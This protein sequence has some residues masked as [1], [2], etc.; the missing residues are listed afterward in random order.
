[1]EHFGEAELRALEPT[2]G[3]AA[4]SASRRAV[5]QL[6]RLPPALKENRLVLFAQWDL[7]NLVRCALAAGASA[8]TRFGEN[9]TPVLSYA[10]ECGAARAVKALLTGGA[11]GRLADKQGGTALHWA[12][13]EGH[14]P[15]VSLLLEAGAP[16]E[17]KNDVGRTALALA[18]GKGHSEAVSLLLGRGAD[19]NTV[20][21]CTGNTPLINCIAGMHVR[22][23][24][25]LLP[26]SDLSITNK[27][28]KNALHASVM[29]A[30][31]DCFKLLLPRMA[32][33]DVRTGPSMEAPTV[34][35]NQTAAHI[36][37]AKGQHKM[38]EKL[39]RRGASRTARDS[40]RCTPLHYAASAGQLSCIV[41]LIGHPEAYKME[42]VDIDV[43]DEDGITPLH[44]AARFGNAK[45]CGLLIAAGARLDA[46]SRN[47][48]TPLM[49][50]QHQHPANTALIDLL[51]GRGP[52][53]PPG[54][55]CDRCSCPEDPA[56]HL[57]PCSGCQVAR[58]CS[59]ACQHAAWAAHEPECGR[60]KAEREESTS[61]HLI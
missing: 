43:A 2:L 9:D 51:A 57:M 48:F 59:V 45:C 17:A 27:Q 21:F 14:T 33:M 29:T 40:Y 7:G 12:A 42:P 36:A 47:G 39:L 28:G 23:V 31:Y 15:C 22:C 34:P 16:L 32:A 18:A 20:D 46:H 30:S 25:Q 19:A 13:Q 10:A 8:N 56:S 38:L 6:A 50:G 44:C 60:L 1:M 35:F 3:N 11:D 24:E 58:Y 26:H 37:C 4:S 52:E 5:L 55:T 41:Q 49:L 61:V 53:H 54:T